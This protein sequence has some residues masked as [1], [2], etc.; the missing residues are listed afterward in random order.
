MPGIL[1]AVQGKCMFIWHLRLI[2][3]VIPVMQK[4]LKFPL[5]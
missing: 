2:Q 1:T 5:T 3:P 4:G